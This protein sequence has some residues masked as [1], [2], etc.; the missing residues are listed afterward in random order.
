MWECLL[1]SME[2]GHQS[3]LLPDGKMADLVSVYE[4]QSPLMSAYRIQIGSLKDYLF[5]AKLLAEVSQ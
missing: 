4:L 1:E 5:L 2:I 3:V